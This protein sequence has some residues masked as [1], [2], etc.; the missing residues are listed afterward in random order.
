M[1]EIVKQAMQAS[2]RTP[3]G[4]SPSV[5]ETDWRET[6]VDTNPWA[7]WGYYIYQHAELQAN[8][9]RFVP[10]DVPTREGIQDFYKKNLEKRD[11]HRFLKDIQNKIMREFGPA[12]VVWDFRTNEP[13]STAE[14]QSRFA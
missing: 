10:D 11:Y 14:Q 6:L 3:D 13:V 2:S 4:A 12:V 1:K 7:A 9:D 8:F 5:D